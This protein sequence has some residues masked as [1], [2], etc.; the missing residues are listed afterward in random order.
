MQ[1]AALGLFV[2]ELAS[3]PFEELGRR[4][5]Y[6]Y[7]SSERVGARDA[8]QF[9]GPGE[10]RLSIRGRLCPEAAGSYGAID[11]LR[12]MAELAD[13]YAFVDGD[14]FIL[15]YFVIIGLDEGQKYFLDNGTPRM[16]DFAIELKR[17]A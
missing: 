6:G 2:F 8:L 15:G 7:A 4:S 12:A 16:I 5:D 3:F 11:T 17:S 9:T 14:G 1:L 13:D 10:D